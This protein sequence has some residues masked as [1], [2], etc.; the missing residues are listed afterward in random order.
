MFLLRETSDKDVLKSILDHLED[1]NS[2]KEILVLYDDKNGNSKE[3]REFKL[4]SGQFK[5][6]KQEMIKLIKPGK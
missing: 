5:L 3:S 6:P 4:T 2:F 1:K